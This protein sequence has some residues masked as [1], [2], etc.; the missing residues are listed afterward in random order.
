[1]M[2]CRKPFVKAGVPYP[3]G[4]CM[5]CRFN[6]R[7]LWASRIMLESL[8]H[9]SSSFVTLT[10]SSNRLPVVNGVPVLV[11]K[12]LQDWLK[13]FRGVIEPV[14]IRFYGVGEYGEDVVSNDV[15]Y[16]Y[17]RP[18][19][20]IIVFGFPPCSRGQTLVNAVTK[21]SRWSECCES[22]RIVGDSWGFGDVF[23]GGVTRD[24]ASYVAEYTVKKMTSVSDPRL[25]GRSPEFC[26]MSLRPGIGC[27][28]M[29]DVASTLLQYSLDERVDVPLSLAEGRTSRQLGRY[30]RSKLRVMIGKDGG[31]PEEV[32]KEMAEEMRPLRESAFASSS[33]FAEAVIADGAQRVA[34]MEAR[35]GIFQKGRKL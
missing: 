22:C 12:H 18:H 20:H 33:S 9:A 7:R 30:L 6:R 4:Q 24:S 16:K 32:L 1:M 8:C 27:D 29:W 23:L 2:L 35:L 21:A 26:R 28:A 17:G 13:R 10:Y 19:Y 3:C 25:K 31:C 5:P 11:P 14:K 15:V 34:N